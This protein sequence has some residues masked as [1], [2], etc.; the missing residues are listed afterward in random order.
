MNQNMNNVFTILTANLSAHVVAFTDVASPIMA[1]GV[2]SVSFLW[3][4]Y[5][6]KNEKRI[7]KDKHKEDSE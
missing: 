6:F 1:I 2:S 7:Y 3:I 5:K 4:L